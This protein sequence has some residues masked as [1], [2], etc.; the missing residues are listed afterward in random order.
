MWSCIH[1]QFVKNVML[2]RRQFYLQISL[3]TEPESVFAFCQACGPAEIRCPTPPDRVTK[4]PASTLRQ[5]SP[6]QREGGTHEPYLHG[7]RKSNVQLSKTEL[8]FQWNCVTFSQLIK[9]LMFKGCRYLHPHR[10]DPTVE[11][12]FAQCTQRYGWP[13]G[14]WQ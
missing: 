9:C 8:T 1:M 3:C 5:R 2:M 13:P 10:R 7:Q 11:L 14:Q 6:G 4:F 12:Q